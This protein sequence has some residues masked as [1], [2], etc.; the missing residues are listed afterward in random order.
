MSVMS[1][2]CLKVIYIYDPLLTLS[3][4][5]SLLPLSKNC[6]VDEGATKDEVEEL[7]VVLMM[8]L[9]VTGL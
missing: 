9:M 7:V 4:S 3:H 6:S 2:H 1:F 8:V 5:N